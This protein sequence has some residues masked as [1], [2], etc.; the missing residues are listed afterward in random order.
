MN[1]SINPD[2]T[3]PN[4]EARISKQ[5][6]MTEIQNPKQQRPEENSLAKSML[7]KSKPSCF[8][9]SVIRISNLFRIS[10]FGFRAFY[11]IR[12]NGNFFPE[13][14]TIGGGFKL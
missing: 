12:R 2:W 8:C 7:L 10:N 4:F 9:H 13:P 5:I 14:S 3:N 6:Q 1:G 11:F